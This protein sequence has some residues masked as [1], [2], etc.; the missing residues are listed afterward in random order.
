MNCCLGYD[1]MKFGTQLNDKPV[2]YDFK[3]S[4]SRGGYVTMPTIE[5]VFNQYPGVKIKLVG[6]DDLKNKVVQTESGS[7]PMTTD[8]IKNVSKLADRVR[9]FLTKEEWKERINQLDTE[10]LFDED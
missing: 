6:V 4:R 3:V 8:D 7:R 9:G 10:G 1:D 2:E 5:E